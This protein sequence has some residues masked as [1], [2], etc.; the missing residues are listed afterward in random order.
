MIDAKHRAEFARAIYKHKYERTD[1]GLYMTNGSRV[2]IGGALK[3]HDYRD[4][5]EQLTDIHANMLLNEGLNHILGVTLPPESGYS[6][7]TKWYLA[8]FSGNYTPQAVHGAAQLPTAATEFTQ[9]NGNERLPLVF[10]TPTAQTSGNSG[11]IATMTFLGDGPYSVYGA[12]IVSS[13]AKSSTTGKALSCIRLANPKT[14]FRQNDRLGFEYVL[15][16]RDEG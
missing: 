12:F 16:A 5:H 3:T 4:G 10:A 1:T 7:I 15:T 13:A 8:P 11:N 9:Y 2:F 14:G 6:Q